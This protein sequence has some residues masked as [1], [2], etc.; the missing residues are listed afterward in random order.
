MKYFRFSSAE[1]TALVELFSHAHQLLH[2]LEHEIQEIRTHLEL[3]A[4]AS[5]KKK[6]CLG[7]FA[8]FL[9]ETSIATRDAESAAKIKNFPSYKIQLKNEFLAFKMCIQKDNYDYLKHCK[10]TLEEKKEYCYSLLF[11]LGNLLLLLFVNDLKQLSRKKQV[12][13]VD[14]VYFLFYKITIVYLSYD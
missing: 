9:D 8:C 7:K 13:K 2:Y 3:F 1:L 4:C 10:C 6:F 14:V 12:F 11:G 5:H